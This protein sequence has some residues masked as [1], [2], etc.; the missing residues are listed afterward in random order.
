MAETDKKIEA[1]EQEVSEASANPQA[2][3][4]KKNAVASGLLSVGL[5]TA[6]PKSSWLAI[7]AICE[8][9]AATAFFLGASGAVASVTSFTVAASDFSVS[10][11]EI[12]SLIKINVYFKSL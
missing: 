9:S 10:A 6:G 1:M 3:A 8:G 5:V 11:I 12:S 4:P 2:D 7:L